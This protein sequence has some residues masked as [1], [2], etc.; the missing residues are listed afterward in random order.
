MCFK[1]S[2][3]SSRSSFWLV[4]LLAVFLFGA[5]IWPLAAQPSDASPPTSASSTPELTPPL[6]L[7]LQADAKLTELNRQIPILQ[8]QIKSLQ[9]SL[10]T[11]SEQLSSSESSSDLLKAQ[12]QD[13]QDKLAQSEK[14]RAVL[15]SWLVALKATY[16]VQSQNLEAVQMQA[17]AVI[18]DYETT[19]RGE[20]AKTLGWKIGGIT[21]AVIGIDLGIKA[22]TGKDI[23]EWIIFLFNKK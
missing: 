8:E 1:S 19:L 6:Q 17:Q 10:A 4:L 16:D 5:T 22:F 14:A 23:I 13:S 18:G 21:V 9:E 11:A 15:Q 3:G 7:L 20:R 2:G 12:L